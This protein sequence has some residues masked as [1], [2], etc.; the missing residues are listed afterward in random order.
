ME[1]KLYLI[2]EIEISLRQTGQQ[3]RQVGGKLIPQS[4][5]D[6]IVDG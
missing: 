3:I 1:G 2:L 5:L 6:E 4:S